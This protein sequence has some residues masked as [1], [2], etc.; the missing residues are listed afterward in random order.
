MKIILFDLGDTLEDSAH[1]GLLPGALTT[2]TALRALRDSSGQAPLLALASDF[3]ALN[4]T[5]AQ[6]NAS[7]QEYVQILQGLGIRQFFKPAA[8]RITLSTEVNAFKPSVK[9]FQAVLTKAGGTLQLRDIMFITEN[10]PHVLAARALGLRAIHFK[11]PGQI[12]GDIT[13]LAELV[14]LVRDFLS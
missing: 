3:G 9:I 11:G 2:L 14:P 8:K 4:A 12:T 7:R 5:A 6:I 10:K 1:G 13:A